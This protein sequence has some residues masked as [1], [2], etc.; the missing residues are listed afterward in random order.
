[1]TTAPLIADTFEYAGRQVRA[2]WCPAPW[3]PPRALTTQCS[4]LC[5]TAD[6]R[7]VLVSQDGRSWALPGGHPEPG[8]TLEEA[9]CREVRE[10][11]CAQVLQHVYLGCQ[12]IHESDG[13]T[14]MPIYYQTRFWARLAL[15][16]FVPLHETAHRL[17]VAPGEVRETLGWS[18]AI[19]D[20]LLDLARGCEAQTATP[21]GGPR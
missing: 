17:L 9:F 19:L 15:D 1:M 6:G 13:A 14:E 4:G 10:E 16:A 7:A 21:A 3:R 5:Y 18:S 12:R 2:V 8:E 20:H 11:A